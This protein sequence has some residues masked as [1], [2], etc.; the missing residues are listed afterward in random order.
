MNDTALRAK[1]YLYL[2]KVR[3]S[4]EDRDGA[5]KYATYVTSLFDEP[6]AVSEAQKIIDAY[7]NEVK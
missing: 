2:A 3:E 5:V 4:I 1:A 7:S 6:D